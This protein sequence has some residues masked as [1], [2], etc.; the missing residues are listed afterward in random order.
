MGYHCQFFSV[1]LLLLLLQIIGKGSLFNKWYS[2]TGQ[3][4]GGKNSYIHALSKT[5]ILKSIPNR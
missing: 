3:L 5:L 1:R 2:A 4:S